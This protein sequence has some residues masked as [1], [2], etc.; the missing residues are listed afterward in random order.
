MAHQKFDIAK[1]DKLNDPGRFDTIDPLLVAAAGDLTSAGTIVDIGAGT[2]LFA[3]RFADLAPRATVYAVDAEPVMIEWMREHRDEVATGR[4]V[5]VLSDETSVPLDDGMADV[6]VMINVHH[7]LAEPAETY[8]EAVRVAR[9]GGRVVVADWAPGDS[10]KGPPQHIRVDADG[11]VQ[12][13][14]SAGLTDVTVY[15]GMPHH[16]LVAGRKP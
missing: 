10:P 8:R 7:E 9:P 1:L 16:S 13:L 11:I 12:A 5:P 15:G 2:G 14:Q 6:V 3:A 4:V